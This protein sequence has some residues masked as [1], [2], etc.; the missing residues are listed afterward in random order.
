[1]MIESDD[2]ADVAW[3]VARTTEEYPGFDPAVLALTLTLYRTMSSFDR[4]HTAE[5]APH[6]LVLSQFN[7]LSV[8]HRATRPLTMGELGQAVS[9]RPAKLT[10]VVD[11]LVR[12]GLVERSL[13]AEDRRSVLVRCSEAG[14]E[15]LHRI[16][17]DHWSYLESLMSELTSRERRQLT[18]LLDRLQASIKAGATARAAGA[19]LDE[20]AG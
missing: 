17:P 7:I 10:G 18:T 5:L 19:S 13:N 12:R 11:A 4:A 2:V 14:E 9:V 1:M 8:L 15:L 16:L 6:G 20:M 3:Q